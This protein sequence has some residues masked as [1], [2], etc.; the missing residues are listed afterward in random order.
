MSV[1]DL[2]VLL[3]FNDW[4]MVSEISL[5]RPPSGSVKNDPCE[6]NPLMNRKKDN[7]IGMLQT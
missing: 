2:L 4:S 5:D 1:S 7:L 6:S 3:L